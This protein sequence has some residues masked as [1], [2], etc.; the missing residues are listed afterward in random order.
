MKWPAKFEVSIVGTALIDS[1][2]VIFK[3][4]AQFSGNDKKSD[5]TDAAVGRIPDTP[6]QY[7]F[8]RISVV[9]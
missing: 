3:I 9:T 2:K 4:W 7:I 6:Q 5:Q 1:C 8:S